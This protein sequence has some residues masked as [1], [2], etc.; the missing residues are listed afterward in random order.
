MKEL[1]SEFAKLRITCMRLVGC[2]VSVN[3]GPMPEQCT[4]F[5]EW[6]EMQLEQ[7]HHG[8][9]GGHCCEQSQLMHREGSIRCVQSRRKQ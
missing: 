8:V 1:P 6:Q 7:Q 9:L 5:L 4:Y 3:S 2:I